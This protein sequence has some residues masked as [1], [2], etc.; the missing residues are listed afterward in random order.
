VVILG[1]SDSLDTGACLVVDDRPVALEHEARHDRQPR[2]RRFPWRATESVLMQ[3]GL[4]ARDVDLIA[5][6][7]RFTPPFFLRRHPE[8]RRSGRDPFSVAVDAKVFF[9]AMLQQTGLGAMEADRAADWLDQRFRERG[10]AHQRIVLV[11]MHRALAAAA[12]RSQPDDSA[13]ILTLHPMGDGVSCAVHRG[14]AGQLDKLWAQRGFSSLHV[15]LQRCASAIGFEPIVEE[16]RLWTAAGRG[17]ADPALVTALETEL[18][19]SG[20]RL[21]R[22]SYPLPESRWE[23]VYKELAASPRDDA[24]ASVYENLRAAVCALVR[25]HVVS[26]G[27]SDLAV[28]GAV[29]D[30]P[31]LCAD[32]A[33][34]DVVDRLWVSPE[35][36][37][38]SLSLGAAMSYAG[39]HPRLLDPPG[40]GQVF[41]PDACAAAVRAAG[42]EAVH[43]VDPTSSIVSALSEGKGVARFVGMGGFSRS[44]SGT[45]S[46]LVR[47][48]LAPEVER[49]RRALGR[50]P[51][52][53][54]VAA[55]LA[56]EPCLEALDM[57]AIRGPLRY[58]AIAPRVPVAFADRYPALVTS[59][60]RAHLLVLDAAADPA[61]LAIVSALRDRTEC[62]ALALW[63]LGRGDDPV[64]SLPGDALRLLREV[65]LDALLLG[66]LWV[67]G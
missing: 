65:R 66:S 5:V 25:H 56:D 49:I 11:D 9:Q 54:P 33:A 8:L 27:I 52:E 1:I 15:H 41:G 36:G 39:L 57:D 12:Y 59:D 58:G 20:P 22:R 60:G 61:L 7:G 64:V 3:A 10:F 44:G 24:A 46:V 38:R 34:L 28:G 43:L 67:S 50:D 29:F 45:R 14:S 6:A 2:S 63:P 23:S 62:G 37:W 17:T 26:H 51:D 30:N 35:P 13:L 19:A 53:E 42:A 18:H 47:A 32:V 16:H 48:D 31:R 21:S 40:L 4:S 55:V